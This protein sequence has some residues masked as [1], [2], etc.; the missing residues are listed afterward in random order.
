ME[1]GLGGFAA[2]G[3]AAAVAAWGIRAFNWVKGPRLWQLWN[4]TFGKVR[5]RWGTR[6]G[7]NPTSRE[8]REKWGTRPIFIIR[9]MLGA[10]LESQNPHPAA[11]NAARAGHPRVNPPQADSGFLLAELTSWRRLRRSRP[12]L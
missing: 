6:L 7:W 3:A 1:R 5:Q 8:V 12:F 2:G 4:P 11:K 9:H 10:A